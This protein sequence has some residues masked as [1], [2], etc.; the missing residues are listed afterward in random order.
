MQSTNYSV[1]KQIQRP[2]LFLCLC[3]CSVTS[4]SISPS[5]NSTEFLLSLSY[6]L[7]PLCKLKM[8]PLFR[9]KSIFYTSS[10]DKLYK[11]ISQSKGKSYFFWCTTLRDC[12]GIYIS[13]F[14]F[15]INLFTSPFITL[16]AIDQALGIANLLMNETT[17]FLLPILTDYP[18]Y[19]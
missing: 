5:F 18:V 11:K 2:S 14:P 16:T 3:A 12:I 4:Y 19:V 10:F 6:K 15:F 1:F 17:S 8:S 7:I 13:L 9:T